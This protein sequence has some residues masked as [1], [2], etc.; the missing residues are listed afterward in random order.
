MATYCTVCPKWEIK[1]PERCSNTLFDGEQKRYFCTK[2]C[3][4][5]YEKAP[6]KFDNKKQA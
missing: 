2:R 3:K 5:R 6:E 1:Q 4:E